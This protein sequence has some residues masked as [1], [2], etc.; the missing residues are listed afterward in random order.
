M[1]EAKRCAV[2]GQSKPLSE[3]HANRSR[4]DGRQSRCKQCHVAPNEQEGER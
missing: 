4:P 3:F 1:A 2:C